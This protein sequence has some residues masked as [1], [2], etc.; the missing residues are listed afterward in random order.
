M[1]RLI[2]LAKRF[3]NKPTS[4]NRVQFLV[5]FN[6]LSESEQFQSVQKGT[7]LSQILVG[8]SAATR[9]EIEEELNH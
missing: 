6:E 9:M 8:W 4:F 7:E 2:T 1:S 5:E 3:A